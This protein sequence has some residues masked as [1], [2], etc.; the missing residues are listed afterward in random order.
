MPQEVPG[1]SKPT[2]W[3]ANRLPSSREVWRILLQSF[4]GFSAASIDASIVTQNIGQ[5]FHLAVL[6]RRPLKRDQ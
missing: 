3:V 1:S 4:T 5:A 2:D 6:I